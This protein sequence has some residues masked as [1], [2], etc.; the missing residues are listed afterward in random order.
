YPEADTAWIGHVMT[1]TGLPGQPGGFGKFHIGRGANRPFSPGPAAGHNGV[2]DF[3]N[4]QPGELDSLQGWWPV[5]CPY[6]YTSGRIASDME[7]PQFAL[8]YG[9]QGNYVLPQIAATRTFGVVGYWHRDGGST[10]PPLAAP[11]TT[12]VGPTWAPL[13]GTASAWCGLR[14][15]GDQAA[16]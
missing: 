12:P 13:T 6:Q 16:V 2:W 3:D 7:R 5:A 15:H 8:D 4:L 10:V 1:S 14:S 11:G 9:N